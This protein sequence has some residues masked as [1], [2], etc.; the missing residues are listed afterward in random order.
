MNRLDYK[1]ISSSVGLTLFFRWIKVF[2]SDPWRRVLVQISFIFM[3]FNI[4]PALYAWNSDIPKENEINYAKGELVLRKVNKKGI[5]LGV[6]KSNKIEYFS[7]ANEL[8][9]G[10]WG[11]GVNDD[12]L[13]DWTGK[14]AEIGW[15]YQPVYFFYSQRRLVMLKVDGEEKIS[16]EMVS[17]KILSGREGAIDS[18]FI[19]TSIMMLL[20]F[21]IKRFF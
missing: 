10:H 13:R 21:L 9:L 14:T 17:E 6:K 15:Y 5:Q 7:C 8:T 3:L 4:V 11:C 18:I 1:N 20:F 19:A 16:L 12:L 2:F